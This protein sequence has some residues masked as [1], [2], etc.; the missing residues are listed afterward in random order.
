MAGDLAGA[1]AAAGA[2]GRHGVAL[3]RQLRTFFPS[4]FGYTVR[5]YVAAA[6]ACSRG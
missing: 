3:V 4:R 5:D 1:G 6:V 2:V